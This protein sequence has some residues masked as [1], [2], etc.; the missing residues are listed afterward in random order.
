MTAFRDRLN[1]AGI[2]ATIRT[3]RG[4]DIQAAC[5]LLGRKSRDQSAEAGAGTAALGGSAG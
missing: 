3:S 5:G 1:D 4:E 2:T